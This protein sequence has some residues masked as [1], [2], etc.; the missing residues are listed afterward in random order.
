MYCNEILEKGKKENG[1]KKEESKIV[2]ECGEEKYVIKR[3]KKEKEKHNLQLMK[4]KAE[5]E[6]SLQKKEKRKE[7][8]W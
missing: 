8:N 6:K 1:G 4:R 3:L 7:L 2:S 5:E